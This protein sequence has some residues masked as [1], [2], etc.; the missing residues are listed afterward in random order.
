MRQ[1]RF[2]IRLLAVCI[3]QNT[4]EA[5]ECISRL[6][7]HLYAL[8][9][10]FEIGAEL[11]S[12]YLG[13]S[14]GDE[15]PSTSL[16]GREYQNNVMFGLRPMA[17]WFP[18]QDL[19]F[20]GEV[21][22]RYRWPGWV[23]NTVQGFDFR[24]NQAFVEYAPKDWLLVSGIQAINFGTAAVLDQRFASVLGGYKGEAFHLLGFFGA[25]MREWTRS[26]TN[27]MFM[28]YAADTIGW[29]TLG[30]GIDNFVAGAMF[31]LYL[32]WHLKVQA[33]YLYSGPAYEW[34]RSHAWSLSVKGPIVR[35]RLSFVLD[36]VG[37]LSN[38]GFFL[39][40]LVAELRG[41]PWKASTAPWLALGAAS[42]F[43]HDQKTRL[44]PVYE[45]L[46]LGLL[47][48]FSLYHGHVFYFRGSWKV[49]G[50][51]APFASYYAQ[52]YELDDISDELDVGAEVTLLAEKL[53]FRAA[54]IAV[55]LA[56]EAAP[57]HAGYFEL[58]FILGQ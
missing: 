6:P 19:S 56:P 27:S 23:A 41:Q 26:A 42:S 58:R 49:T 16:D 28:R 30:P 52:S 14:V 2:I 3:V 39:P 50:Y 17:T 25:T 45:N 22:L 38:D 55:N 13:V 53:L 35:R 54:Y 5:R 57:T 51:V 18:H 40:G 21:E 24:P 10:T 44:A 34:L 8:G 12:F 31:G 4:A 29:K 11:R 15:M 37:L 1:H 48:R 33:L 7:G 46:S 43:R 36:V 9:D 20:V 32:P 47:R